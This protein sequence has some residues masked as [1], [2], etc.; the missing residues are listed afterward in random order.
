MPPADFHR[1]TTS[2]PSLNPRGSRC[3]DI[4]YPIFGPSRRT[5]RNSRHF[6]CLARSSALPRPRTGDVATRRRATASSAERLPDKLHLQ[7]VRQYPPLKPAFGAARQERVQFDGGYEPVVAGADH[8][9]RVVAQRSGDSPGYADRRG[10]MAVLCGGGPCDWRRYV[11]RQ[12]LLRLGR[13]PVL[14]SRHRG[15]SSALEPVAARRRGEKCSA[16]VG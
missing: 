4:Q 2:Y 8:A 16:T 11:G 5:L 10:E 7:W 6:S 3:N 1:L 14:L 9:R 12:G 15:R 13:R